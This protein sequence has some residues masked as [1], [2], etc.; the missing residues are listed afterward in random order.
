MGKSLYKD[1]CNEEVF[2]GLYR[3]WAQDLSNYVYYK[4]GNKV[5][6]EDK[7]QEAF[8]KLWEHCGKTPPEKA[9]SFLFTV[10]N[11]L[12]LN[13]LKHQKVVLKHQQVKPKERTNQSPEFQFL[14][15]EY[16]EKFERALSS[17]CLLYT[18]PS[19]RDS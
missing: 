8:L 17:F 10:I 16:M 12:S 1:S 7:V 13:E 3:K 2:S 15:K 4:F 18:S 5:R 19:P 6:P 11:N 9:K 14:E